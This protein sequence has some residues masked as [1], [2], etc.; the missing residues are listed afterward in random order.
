[1]S[2]PSAFKSLAAAAVK[3]Y[4]RDKATLF[5]T[6][7]FPLMFLLVFGLI[8]QDTGTDKIKLGVVGD[9]PVISA[10]EKTGTVEFERFDSMDAAVTKVRD[11][12]LPGLVAQNGDKVTVRYAQSDQTRAAMVQ[13]LVGG[14]VDKVNVQVTGQAPRFSVDSTNVED[15][16]LKGIQY[17]TPGILS[18]AVAASAVFGAAL[19]LVTWRKKQVLRRLRLAPINASTVLSARVAVTIGV[20]VVQA[21]IF[22]GLALLPIFGLKLSGTWYLSIPVFLLGTVAFFAIGMLVG[23]FAKT[24]DA[25]VGA[26][27]IVVLPMAFLS[28]TFFPIDNAPGWLKAVSNVF[29]LRHMND[30]MLNFLVRGKGAEALLLPCGV[31]LGF[32]V[33]VGFIASRVFSWED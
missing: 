15:Q 18:W 29:P 3:G 17:I 23:A 8:F 20:A 2:R 26:A 11:G 21:V 14:V 33:V 31:L 24:E 27:N 7:F 28:G 16:S 19:T 12:D 25:A 10:L 32:T 30:G 13:G 9:G 22:V 4:V 1:M 6:F 5:F